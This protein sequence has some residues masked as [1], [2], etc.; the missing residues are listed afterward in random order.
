MPWNEPGGGRD[1]WKGRGGGD[2]PPDLDEVVRRMQDR[3]SALFGVRSG[4]SAPRGNSSMWV[5]AVV[6]AVVALFLECAYT[7][8]PAERG[9]VLRFG[10]N[11]A[12][13][14]PGFSLRLPRPIEY[15]E[16]VNVDLVR[17]LP[18]KSSMLTRD[19]NIVDIDLAV[20]YRIQNVTEYLFNTAS[21]DDA[22]RRAMETS[23]R[24]VIGQSEMD[25]VLKEGRSEV[26][27]RAKENIQKLLGEYGTGLLVTDVNLLKSGPPEEV[28]SA[29]DDATKAREDQQRLINEAEAYRNEV[30]P[31]ARGAAARINEEAVAYKQ[32]VVD[33]ATGDTNRFEKLLTEY[34]KAPAVT[35]Q[36]M[37]LDTMEQVFSNASKVVVATGND[38]SNL[39][40]LPID[41]LIQRGSV[42]T[43]NLGTAPP[44]PAA[45]PAPDLERRER[46]DYR[47][48]EV[49]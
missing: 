45:A 3:L 33:Q 42:T 35:R 39:I 5:L 46:A 17:S 15:V 9:V 1:P 18:Y 23:V 30:L 10:Q 29:F 4:G 22:V 6:V 47:A 44:V 36:R 32:R 21:P 7:I 27:S 37:Y 34:Q 49:R 26:E 19:E 48:R 16:K 41:K 11:V 40:Y 38:A 13:L 20:Q 14:Q 24:E 2:G 12:T 31:T 25:F 28:K 8:A 43:T